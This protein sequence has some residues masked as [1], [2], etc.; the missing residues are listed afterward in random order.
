MVDFI[1][2]GL[3]I[4]IIKQ[5]Y[6]CNEMRF[7]N[8]ILYLFISVNFFLQFRIIAIVFSIKYFKIIY[9]AIYIEIIKKFK[10]FDSKKN[11]GK[12]YKEMK[13]EKRITLKKNI[14]M[15]SVVKIGIVDP[16]L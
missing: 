13:T 2:N 12:I 16:D 8:P 4:R 5:K 11:K 14:N 3:K 10:K 15:F 1:D 6:K 7:F 9:N